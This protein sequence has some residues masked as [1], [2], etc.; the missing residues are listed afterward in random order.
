LEPVAES[1]L[2]SILQ[3]TEIPNDMDTSDFPPGDKS[4]HSRKDLHEDDSDSPLGKKKSK[5]H[6][7]KHEKDHK[8]EHHT[9]KHH[10]HHGHH[11]DKAWG[12][13]DT[14]GEGGTADEDNMDADDEGGS[15]SDATQDLDNAE[16]KLSKATADMKDG[17]GEE[18]DGDDDEDD[19]E[20]EDSEL[21]RDLVSVMESA[22][23]GQEDLVLPPR[24]Q[25][26]SKPTRQQELQPKMQEVLLEKDHHENKRSRSLAKKHPT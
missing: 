8:K 26:S 13:G 4:H 20:D 5:H 3:E 15:R 12:R 24:H 23:R 2:P 10:K 18:G 25:G 21:M 17:D 6:M 22:Q 16:A 7:H 14:V 9:K 19:E 1:A 11:H